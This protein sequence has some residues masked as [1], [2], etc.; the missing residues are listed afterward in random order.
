MQR[1]RPTASP[2]RAVLAGLLV[3][4]G[5]PRGAIAQ[6]SDTLYL[7]LSQAVSRALTTA[8]EMRRARA[9]V[10]VADAQVGVARASAL[11][12]LRLN[13]A[14]THVL[15]NARAQAVGSIFNQPNVYTVNANL[16][17]TIFQGG[18]AFYGWRA[19]RR[20]RGA[21]RAT[22][23][24]TR[25]DLEMSV[26]RAYVLALFSQR[27]V[28]IQRGNLDLAGARLA[29]TALQLEAGRV[30]RYDLL[31]AR[32]ERAN[33][34]PQVIAAESDRDVAMLDLQQLVNIPPGTPVALTSRIE[35][36]GFETLL[37]S[38]E[39]DVPVE[40]SS[41]RAA[42]LTV[43]ARRAALGASRADWLPTVSAFIQSG[44]QAFPVSGLPAWRGEIEVVDC[45]PGGTPGRVCTAQNG[46]FFSDRSVGVTM[47]W[48]L[49]DGLRAKSNMDLARAQ[50]RLAE[51]DLRLEREQADAAVVL[52][53]T[54]LAR[55]RASLSA[56]RETVG[57]AEETFQLA[58]LRRQRGVGTALE[59][60][61]AQL[62]Q[63][64]ART[65]AARAQLDVYVAAA[66][67]AR[68][69][70]RP[71]PLPGDVPQAPTP[72]TSSLNSGQ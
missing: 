5:A 34:E 64:V 52:A 24:E 27:I 32:V 60:S 70:G 62:A 8:D 1:F 15:E 17:Q 46:G 48:P 11:P 58:T 57:E 20:V 42:E 2:V 66:E 37:A 55:A 53:R 29:Q 36:G 45:E 44:Y 38:L 71:I 12:Q 67:L 39:R 59:V 9:E 56:R 13:S 19:A 4:A 18:R 21:A 54:Q 23:D 49:F 14:Y 31:R 7:T 33:L 65:E 35:T 40:R 22:A 16:S 61:D 68:A 72:A 6:R 50:L 51:T 63:L 3:L 43:E 41:V 26:V 47:T 28:D 25:A 30:A 10:D 69:L